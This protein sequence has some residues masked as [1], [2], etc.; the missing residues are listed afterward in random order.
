MTRTPSRPTIRSATDADGQGVA[1]LVA[2]CF[3]EYDGCLYEPAEFPELPAI[4]S[5]VAA[6]GGFF[7]VAESEGRIVGSAGILPTHVPGI[8]ELKKLYVAPRHR[9]TGLAAALLAGATA[10]A[11]GRGGHAIVLFSDTRFRRGHAFYEKHGFRRLP[12]TRN[13]N[14]VSR[15]LEYAYRIDLAPGSAA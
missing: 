13:L 8:L 15:T 5:W 11:R 10:F 14:D 3:A 1:E 9:G 2:H 4:A 7:Q 6:R 12:G